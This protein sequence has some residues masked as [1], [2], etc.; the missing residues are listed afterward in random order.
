MKRMIAL[1]FALSGLLL[2]GCGS[3]EK[4]DS[5]SSS[6][7][8]TGFAAMKMGSKVDVASFQGG[9]GIDMFQ[10]F[11]KEF[12][13]KNKV[14]VKVTGDPRIWLQLQP[15]FVGGT[16]PDL[17]W[18]G[19]GMDYWKL[20]KEKQLMQLDEALDTM[21]ADGKTKWRDTFEPGLLALGQEEGKTWMLPYHFNINGWWANKTV[22]DKHGLTIPKT[23][24]E[25]L[26][27]SE[28]LKA[29]GVAP[30]TFQGQYPYYSIFGFVLPWAISTGGMKA[31]DDMQNLVPGAW[32][33]PGVVKAAEMMAELKAKGYFQNGATGM[34]HT[35]SQTEFLLGKAA[36][37]PC[38]TW[39]YAEMKDVWPKGAEAVFM[40]PPTLAAGQDTSNVCVGIEPWVIPSKAKNPVG[41]VNLYKEMTSVDNA[42]R[43]IEAK[44]TLM[45]IKGANEKAKLPP[46]LVEPARLFGES[47]AVWSPMF[48]IWYPKFKKALEGA[49]SQLM[50]SEIT[51][52]QFA[53]ACEA[54]AEETRNDA[55]V[56]KHKY[57]RG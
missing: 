42:V 40:L 49:T 35:E 18:P 48:S 32:K 37:I 38:G 3:G 10:E 6:P 2:T 4:K 23:Y 12:A 17:T 53:D 43:F 34:S 55:K 24:E 15:R 56:M 20:V 45:G 26:A 29:K 13:A 30:I 51:P 47:K 28:Q 50:N 5:T 14:E 9:Y 41:G 36:M 11:G 33:S 57:A 27:V 54:A 31:L 1:S 25:L 46:H 19:W 52:A 21:A 16:P 7:G 39:L 44:G 8:S 22:F